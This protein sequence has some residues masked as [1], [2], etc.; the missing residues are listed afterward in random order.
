MSESV[1]HEALTRNLQDQSALESLPIIS[2]SFLFDIRVFVAIGTN[3]DATIGI[4]CDRK[5]RSAPG[6]AIGLFLARSPNRF[7]HIENHFVP[8]A[9]PDFHVAVKVEDVDHRTLGNVGLKCSVYS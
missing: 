1:G 6:K 3:D 5:C 4:R 7:P 9:R 8:C 2:R